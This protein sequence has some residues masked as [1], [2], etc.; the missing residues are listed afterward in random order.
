[1]CVYTL[2]SFQAFELD[3]R[4]PGQVVTGLRKGLLGAENHAVHSYSANV[5]P[6][7]KIK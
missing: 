5:F 4:Q 1:M 2:N 7:C 6:P 3:S